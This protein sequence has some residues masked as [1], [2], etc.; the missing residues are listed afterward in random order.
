LI[1]LSLIIA[2][3]LPLEL[4]LFA[5]AVLGPAH[6]LTEINWLKNQGFYTR[7]SNQV[8]ILTGLTTVIAASFLLPPNLNI[9]LGIVD[10]L[11]SL[12]SKNYGGMIFLTLVLSIGLVYTRNWLV[13]L[14]IMTIGVTAIFFFKNLSTFRILTLFIP[15]LIHVY[16]FTLLFMV[17]G[18]LRSRNRLEALAI[19]LFILGPVILFF[20]PIDLSYYQPNEA[21]VNQFVES[22]F[23]S[24]SFS[25]ATMFTAETPNKEQ[26]LLSGIG[27]KVQAF[28]AFAYT[29]HY[30]NWFAK[31]S[32]IGWIKDTNWVNLILIATIWI[33]AVVLYYVDYKTGLTAPFF[34][35]LLHVV[36]EF[37]LN[38]VVIKKIFSP[39]A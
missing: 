4:F 20:L 21:V 22:G 26:F 11:P 39:K 27:L 3:F 13:L 32:I 24:L 25:L 29:Y 33:G 14:L 19:G 31:V 28:V 16:L 6:Y 36:L 37:P 10:R 2:A 30:L 18:A 15:T 23:N 1:V 34:L 38:V 35:S 9:G 17:S 7:N 12:L 5:Y 8:W